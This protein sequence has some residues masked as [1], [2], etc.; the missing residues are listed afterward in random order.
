MKGWLSSIILEKNPFASD[1]NRLYKNVLEWFTTY[2]QVLFSRWLLFCFGNKISDRNELMDRRIHFL[3]PFWE[4]PIYHRGDSVAAVWRGCLFICGWVRRERQAA[5]S[6]G[7]LLKS[8]QA[9]RGLNICSQSVCHL[10]FLFKYGLG[11]L[12]IVSTWCP[13]SG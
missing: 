13:H 9:R 6:W 8:G 3:T 10:F 11:P 5:G 2:K 4:C 12:H 1:W 7:C